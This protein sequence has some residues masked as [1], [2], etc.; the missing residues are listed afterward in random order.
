MVLSLQRFTV[1]VKDWMFENKLKL[2]MTQTEGFS[3][4][5]LIWPCLLPFRLH[6]SWLLQHSVHTE[7]KVPGFWLDSDLITK[8]HVIKICQSVYFEVKSISSIRQYLTEE[9]TKTLVTS[10]IL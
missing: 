1:D 6:L 3:D 4:P 10:C 5:S 2:M 8:Q 9:A 7:S